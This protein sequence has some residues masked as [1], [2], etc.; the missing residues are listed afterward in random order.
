MIEK[1]L[2]D[3]GAAAEAVVR[4]GD[5]LAPPP[6]AQPSDLIFLDP[7][8]GKGLAE[9][10]LTALTAAGWIADGALCVIELRKTDAVGAPDGFTVIDER[11]YGGTRVIL[12]T[13]R[14]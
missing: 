14:A 6:A 7:P 10:A 8:Y 9:P 13:R 4:Q 11:Q 2:A 12:L 5:C 3:C 1:N